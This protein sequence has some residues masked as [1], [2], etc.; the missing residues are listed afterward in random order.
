MSESAFEIVVFHFVEAIHVELSHKAVYFFVSEVPG[1]DDLFE[2]HNILDDEL[3]AIVRPI[4]YLLVL[5][6][7][8][9]SRLT[10][11]ISKVL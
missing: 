7:L 11:R 8:N 4:H 1:Q 2:L 6:H 9:K 10:P 5:L 3:K